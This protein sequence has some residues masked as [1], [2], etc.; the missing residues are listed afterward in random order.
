VAQA[1]AVAAKVLRS[2]LSGKAQSG[3]R[4]LSLDDIEKGARALAAS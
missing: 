3:R 4:H 1:S 2:I